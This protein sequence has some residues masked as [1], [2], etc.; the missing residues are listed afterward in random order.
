M[1]PTVFIMG[2][3]WIGRTVGSISNLRFMI[4]APLVSKWVAMWV[5]FALADKPINDSSKWVPYD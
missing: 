4:E 1:I 5:D 3:F 2:T